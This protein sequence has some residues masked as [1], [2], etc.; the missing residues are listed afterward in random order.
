MIKNWNDFYHFRAKYKI[1]MRFSKNFN[2]FEVVVFIKT[3]IFNFKISNFN[4]SL[5]TDFP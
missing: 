5:T 1:I 2:I 3:L 4:K